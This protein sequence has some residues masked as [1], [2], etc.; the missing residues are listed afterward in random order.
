MYS[1]TQ[2][3]I[4]HSKEFPKNVEF[5]MNEILSLSKTRNFD[6][7]EN[8]PFSIAAI[9]TVALIWLKHYML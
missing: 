8:V 1:R 3:L 7:K 5:D 4:I 6:K 9:E 2:I